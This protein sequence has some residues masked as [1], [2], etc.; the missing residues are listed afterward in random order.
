MQKE[1]RHGDQNCSERRPL[2]L[3]APVETVS[4]V[5]DRHQAQRSKLM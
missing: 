2:L 3:M 1:L 5:F 4:H